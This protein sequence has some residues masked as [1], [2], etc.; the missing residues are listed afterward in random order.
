MYIRSKAGTAAL[1]AAT[2][3]VYALANV[4]IANSL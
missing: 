4:G 2:G 1:Q 3:I